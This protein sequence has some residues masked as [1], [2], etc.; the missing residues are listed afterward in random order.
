MNEKTKVIEFGIK[1]IFVTNFNINLKEEFIQKEQIG[2][3]PFSD[4]VYEVNC[5]NDA[6][7]P[8]EMIVVETTVK[9]FLDK[10]KK[11][12][13]GYLQ[14]ENIFAVKDLKSLYKE[15]ENKL[16]LP[17]EFEASLIGISLSHTRAILLTKCAGTFLQY[18]ILPIFRPMDFLKSK[19]EKE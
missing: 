15:S 5:K 6:H 12:E 18:A 9:V 8:S 4:F 19:K 17:A 2:D 14:I 3:T 13:L 11:I 7:I 16:E 10:E 1:G